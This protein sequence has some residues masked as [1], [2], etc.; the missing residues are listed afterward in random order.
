VDSGLGRD[1]CQAYSQPPQLEII[2]SD[3]CLRL[4]GD[5]S[6]KAPAP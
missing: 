6:T 3:Y 2:D 5:N 1:L 4:F